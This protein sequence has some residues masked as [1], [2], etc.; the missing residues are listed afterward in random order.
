MAAVAPEH[1]FVYGSLLS[2]IPVTARPL[3]ARA[4]FA[5]LSGCGR[6]IGPA[7]A[8]GRLFAVAWYPGFVP[9]K[10]PGKQVR[11]EVWR[12]TH[13]DR[14][15]AAL[16]DYEGDGYVRS[17]IRA[18]LDTGA[19]LEA[20]AYLLANSPGAAPRIESGDY[21]AWLNSPPQAPA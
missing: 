7:S 3:E 20:F 15:L 1:L 11:G 19:R 17:R 9:G 14:L 18:K 5:E 6:L 21:L 10:S 13:P 16:D 4:P 8:S 2:G 12:L